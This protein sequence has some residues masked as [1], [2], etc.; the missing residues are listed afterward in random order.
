MNIPQTQAFLDTILAQGP[1]GYAFVDRELRYAAVNEQL[2]EINGLPAA[3]HLGRLV[4]DVLGPKLWAGRRPL[5]ERA[6]GGEA[7]TDLR[8]PGRWN[9][10]DR[11]H[12]SVLTSYC[13]VWAE[14]AVIGVTVIVHDVTEQARAEAALAVREQEYRLVFD[15]N[16]QPMW[17]YDTETLRFLEVN[18]AAVRV[19]GY[20]RSEFLSM[21]IAE[22]RLPEDVPA[23]Q[24]SVQAPR[25]GAWRDGPWRDGPWRHLHRAG[26][27]V[28]VEIAASSLVFHGRPARLILAMDVTERQAI[29]EEKREAA[30]REQAF[31]RDVLASVT[32]GKLQLCSTPGQLPPLLA[33]VSEALPLTADAGLFA[34]RRQVEEYA[35]SAGL[36]GL[37]QHDLMTAASEAGMN[38]IVHGGGGT[39]LVSVS[40]GGAVQVRVEDHGTGIAVENL[41]R[42]ALE[43][44]FSTKATLGH[45][46]KMMLETADRLFLLTGPTGTTLVLEQDRTP[47][48]PAWL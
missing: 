3:A 21:T 40:P 28:W 4:A 41:P 15:A 22:I 34:L 42:A 14:G 18:D 39:A 37:R 46:L 33:T 9:A 27:E 2:A 23:M 1:V 20:S 29:E 17:V 13:P 10:L 38:A 24:A 47:P 43:R 44:G 19:Y 35:A 26:A 6:L 12:G 5:F 16:P 31:L 7:V 30:R 11:K 32:E 45:G 8:L 36:D 25:H 48:S